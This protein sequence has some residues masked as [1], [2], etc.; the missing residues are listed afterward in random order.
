ML[1]WF[2]SLVCVAVLLG[3]AKPD[4]P[5]TLVRA[6]SEE[7]LAAFRADLVARFGGPPLAVYDTALQELQL[8]GMDRGLTS[9]AARAAAMREQVNG[10]TVRA[11]E[12]LGWQA[13]RSRL[14]TEI[15]QLTEIRAHQI[16]VRDRTAATGTP[17]AVHDRIASAE[18]V[19][20]KLRR[21]LAETEQQLGAL[22][23]RASKTP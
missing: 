3:C 15:K 10:Q 6:G 4:L 14:L 13:R 19:L 7:E 12:V 9:A 5:N 20:A 11:V 1:R 17:P 21:H 18:E 2:S 22:G 16:A 23:A 8:A